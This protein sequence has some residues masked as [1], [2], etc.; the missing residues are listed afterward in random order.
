MMIFGFFLLIIGKSLQKMHLIAKKSILPFKVLNSHIKADRIRLILKKARCSIMRNLYEKK[1]ILFAVSWIVLYC[2]V[3]IP[4]RGKYGDGSIWSL[5]GLAAITIAIAAVCTGI[6]LWKPLG[7]VARPK[8]LRLCLYFIPMW[9]LATGNIWDGFHLQYSGASMWY[10]AGSMVLIGFIEEMIFR[11]FLFRAL[12][13]KRG[14][15]IAVIISAVTFG[16]GHIVNLLAGMATTEN[17]LMIVFAIAWGF[18]FTMVYYRSGRLLSCIIAHAVVD[19]L[20]V[21]SMETAWGTWV[22]IAAT[23]IIG[24]AYSLWLAKVPGISCSAQEQAV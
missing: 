8:N 3:T 13:K 16:I 21:F 15:V 22:Y 4:I 14:P 20:S 1:P 9:I 2:A 19:V 18:V 17:L 5:V 24:V 12:L 6:S 23:I 7:V 10:A 11:G